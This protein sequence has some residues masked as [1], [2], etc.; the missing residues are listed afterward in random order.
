MINMRERDRLRVTTE[1]TLDKGIGVP[2]TVRTSIE[3]ER[4]IEEK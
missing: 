3:D 4:D 2:S 1:P